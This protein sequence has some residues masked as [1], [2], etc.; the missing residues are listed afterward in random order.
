M[1]FQLP[2]VIR[3]SRKLFKSNLYFKGTLSTTERGQ[4]DIEI[5]VK[6]GKM[7]KVE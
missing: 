1:E 7:N 6:K 3:D 5:M 2:K 4:R